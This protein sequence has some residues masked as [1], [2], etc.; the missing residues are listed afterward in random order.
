MACVLG[1]GVLHHPFPFSLFLS[2][3]PQTL[4]L[5]EKGATMLGSPRETHRA[6]ECSL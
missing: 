6:K 5:Q 4:L 3:S 1:D 2:P